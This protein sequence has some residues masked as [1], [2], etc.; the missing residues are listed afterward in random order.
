MLS[1]D[2]LAE[3]ARA[4]AP[5]AP[6]RTPVE[7]AGTVRVSGG[8]TM[9]EL[10]GSE[11]A[12]PVASTTSAVKDGDRVRAV[13]TGHGVTITGN[14]TDPSAS[15]SGLEGALGQIAE[16][17]ELV[18]DK[19]STGELDAQIARID[20]LTAND[21][22]IRGTLSAAEADI[23]ELRADVADLGDLS[24]VNAE[25]ENL[26]A[27]KADITLLEA[28][29]A[30]IENL[31]ATNADI[32]N[33]EVDYGSFKQ[34]TTDDF[35]AVNADIDNLE[36][37]K[38]SAEQADIKY[39][40]I[41]FANIGEAAIE[42]LF[43]KS[44]II[45]DL[46]MDDGHVTGTLVGVTIIGD[47]IEGGTVK[48]DKLVVQGEDGLYYKLNVSGESVAAEQ[49]EYNSL[50]GSII[51]ANTITAEKI[52]VS[53]LV[54]FDATIGGFKITEDSIYSG[55]KS[56]ATNTTRGVFMNDDGEFA[57]GDQSNFLKFFKDTDG[58]YKLA[59]SANSI[60][61]GAS[62]A[63]FMVNSVEEFYL[64][65]SR[66]ALSGGSWSE[67]APTATTGKYIWRRTKVTFSD[68]SVEYSPSETGVCISGNDGADGQP[69]ADGQD[70]RGISSTAV[71]YQAS[72]SGTTIPTGTWSSSIPSVSAGQYLWTRTVITYTK[73]SPSSTTAYSVGR[74]GQNG[75]PGAA[76]DDGRGIQSTAVTYQAGA[77][78]TS[79]P[80]STWTSTV[81]TLTTLLPYLWTRTIITYTDNTTSTS[82]SVS[83]TLES[84]EVGGRNLVL[85]SGD[86]VSNSDY[87]LGNWYLSSGASG[88]VGDTGHPILV[89]GETY[90]VSVKA[91]IATGSNIEWFR[92]YWTGMITFSAWTPVFDTDHVYTK[93]FI[94]DHTRVDTEAVY[95]RLTAY[96]G[97]SNATR[98]TNTIYWIKI[99]KGT[100]A[101]DW[102]P[103]PE[104]VQ[105]GIDAAQGTA[106]DA[107][108][109]ASSLEVTVDA[110]EGRVQDAEGDISTLTQTS[111]SLSSR[112]STAE[113][114][115]S[116]LEQTASSLASRISSAEGDISSL[117][118][119]AEGI[120][121]T[122]G[123][124]SS[125]ANAAQSTAN[126]AN[127]RATHQFGT[128]STAAGTAAKVVALSGFTRYTG[129]TVAVRFTNANT[130]ANPTLNVNSTG[131]AQIRAYNAA[132]TASSAYN[133]V[134]NAV[135][136]FVFDG[137]YWNV[138]DAAALSKYSSVTQT[139]NGLTT[140]VA[141][142]EGDI[143][144]LEQTASGLEVRLD[145]AGDDID[146]A[147]SA[148][149]AA[150]S[151]AN[152]ANSTANS[153]RSTANAANSTANEAKTA[154][155]NAA[156]TATNYLGFSSNGLV[157]GTNSSGSGQSGLQGNVRLYNGGME[158][159]NGSTVLA[160]YGASKIE[161]GI[162]S[163]SSVVDMCGG[164]SRIQ[165]NS[166]GDFSISSPTGRATFGASSFETTVTGRRITLNASTGVYIGSTSLERWV[167][168]E[169]FPVGSVY[170]AYNS[171]SPASRFG[172]TWTAITGRFP[173]F[174][175]GTGTGGSNTHTLTV[176][177][178]PSHTHPLDAKNTSSEA[179]NYGLQLGG[180]FGNRVWVNNNGTPIN[181]YKQGGAG[182]GKS[183]NNM[184]AYQTFYAWRRTA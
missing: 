109:K 83:S 76:G 102:T 26:K 98:G 173:Y 77:S 3:V 134:A 162:N 17:G 73:G 150:Q 10:D 146:A 167:A 18:A 74:M 105:Q 113:G 175:A 156:K 119:T 49:T 46:V 13:I 93:T 148:A 174:N 160:R 7:A 39:A 128:C 81:P 16:V 28:E 124:V 163:K 180:G 6:A 123:Q 4:A 131:A 117:E 170:I 108:E 56:S 158:V 155:T 127:A 12:C 71:T 25:I 63:P 144:T 165:A 51:T 164:A 121:S 2:L 177:Q 53:D 72:S 140:R 88:E 132:L 32:H 161:L 92:L 182:S 38:L 54:A 171:T 138:S 169:L 22:E 142:A 99:E 48:A 9:V 154:A 176:E 69:G 60:K 84:F 151:T 172:G 152:T 157:V 181:W 44:G 112:V 115:I 107:Y 47:L 15:S 52:N 143:S 5:E 65:T 87:N 64:S 125:V 90:T 135:V 129:A 147:Q 82:Y 97:P 145:T 179:N 136:T 100:K 130:A 118:Q 23:E 58:S 168:D 61:F 153:A 111:N 85:A 120:S 14:L 8:R 36:A 70:G 35:E 101:T 20:Q 95:D 41:D 159:R 31:E 96:V 45:G 86:K 91:N 66:T 166:D 59:I 137:T 29:Y 103:A 75:S 55:V 79:A 122:V 183:H 89:E 94:A 67:T 78:Q 57:I 133:W 1:G 27:T 114:D 42:E 178:L 104:D 68:E 141:N 30:T 43:T 80:T 139:V 62:S 21:A 110:I 11:G 116:S 50:N 24:A 19:V 149:S 40:Q 34:L 33:L 184:P 106:D 37:T 126:T